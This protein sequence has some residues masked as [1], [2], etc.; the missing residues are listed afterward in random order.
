[1]FHDA[2]ASS[3]RADPNRSLFEYAI[4]LEY[5]L[6]APGRAVKD[7]INAAAW[8]KMIVKVVSDNDMATWTRAERDQYY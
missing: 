3:L 4:R 5:Y 6:Y 8:L 7:W 1:M 2:R